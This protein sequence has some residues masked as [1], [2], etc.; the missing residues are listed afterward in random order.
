LGTSG[1]IRKSFELGLVEIWRGGNW[2]KGVKVVE[3][4]GMWVVVNFYI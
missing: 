4:N 2:D 3:K 1:K